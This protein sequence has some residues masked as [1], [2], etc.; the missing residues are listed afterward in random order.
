M[1]ILVNATRNQFLVIQL[2]RTVFPKLWGQGLRK[3]RVMDQEMLNR[4]D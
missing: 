3:M 4:V 1:R 2:R